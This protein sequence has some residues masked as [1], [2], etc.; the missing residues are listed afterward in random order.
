MKKLVST[1]MI[2]AMLIPSVGAQSTD[3]FKKKKKKKG[4]TETV[5]KVNTDSLANRKKD[6]LQPYARVITPKAKTMNGFFKV[7]HVEGKYYFEIPDSLFGR[8]VLIVNRIVKAPVDMQ[9]RKVG[10][11]GDQIGDEVIRFEKGNGDKLF[12]REISYIEHSSDT[13]GLYQAV[14]NSN[15]Q[16]IIATFPLKTVRKEGETSNYVIDMTDYIRRDNKLFSFASRAKNN[17]GIGGMVDDASYIDTLKAFPR[18]IEVRTVRTFQRRASSPVGAGSSA[19]SAPS[20]PLTYELNSSMMLL[21]KEPMKS[22]LYDSRVG[23][24]AVSYKD[25]DENPQGVEYKAKITRW[26][27]EPKDE[28]IEKY[29]NGELVE[30]KNPIV[31]YI[32]PATPK[33]WVP[34]L[35]QGVNDWQSAFEKAGFKNAILGKEAPTDDPTWSLED[36]RHSAI[37]Y[38]PS[39]IPN[40]SGPHV[41]DPRNQNEDL[42]DDAVL[43][44]TYGIKN[45]KRIMPEIMNWTYEPNEGYAKASNL[46]QNVVG[47]FNLYMRHVATNV[48][49]IYSTPVSVEQTDVKAMEYVP[50]DIQRKA[51]TFLNKELFNTPT[52]LMD[53]KL[54]ERTRIN[55]YNSVFR[56]QSSILKQLLS[57]NTLDKMTNDEL[58][59]GTK[60]Y[61]TN[62]LFTDLKKG[63]W[64]DLQGGKR[65]DYA[66]RNLQKVYVDALI[67]M[68]DKPRGNSTSLLSM[69]TSALSSYDAP[70]EAPTIARG[71]LI[72]LRRSLAGAASAST[73]IVRSHYLNLQALIDAA[74]EAR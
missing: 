63:I 3:I 65:P 56:V 42:G 14:L 40:A 64:S 20:S 72:E 46:Y 30:P 70:S 2:L 1:L 71:Q 32:D 27:L 55:T 11:P 39:D 43:A 73:G 33:K 54:A 50:K 36:A 49:G 38:K 61:T 51:V 5:A 12:V 69:M 45:L 59:N 47:Q 13:L 44:S 62:N 16:P 26:R 37:V 57:K 41:H 23:Y 4:K 29:L 6:A 15:V 22:R 17:A 24:F 74:F 52:W 18:N 7:H 67:S 34:Y 25:F 19:S 31:I 9:K 8:D 10:Y 53:K 68:I 35:I 66:Q 58:L 28:D 21:P 60:A 48:G